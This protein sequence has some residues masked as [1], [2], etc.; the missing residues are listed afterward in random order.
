MENGGPFA[1]A[2]DNQRRGVNEFQRACH[3]A[4]EAVNISWLSH[5]EERQF[6]VTDRRDSTVD[7][8]DDPLMKV[9]SHTRSNTKPLHLAAG[10]LGGLVADTTELS[11]I[12][13]LRTI[14][15]PRSTPTRS[16]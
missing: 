3:S 9:R 13:H 1:V 2:G 7:V 8:S 5:G 6:A 16:A 4:V 12:D 10:A 14:S 15:L 11:D